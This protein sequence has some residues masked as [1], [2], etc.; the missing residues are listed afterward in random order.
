[1]NRAEL[2]PLAPELAMGV[3]T[4][5]AALEGAIA[6]GGA[7]PMIVLRRLEGRCYAAGY[8]TGYAHGLADSG[9]GVRREVDAAKG[10]ATESV[11]V[12]VARATDKW[13]SDQTL[14]ERLHAI[15]NTGGLDA[16]IGECAVLAREAVKSGG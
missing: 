4:D 15:A 5:L 16:L 8:N 14:N 1:V 7:N 11:G 2:V 10:S 12:R 13:L 9:D 6:D 3:S